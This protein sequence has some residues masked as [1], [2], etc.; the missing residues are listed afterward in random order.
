MTRIRT[1][2]AAGVIVGA[3][4]LGGAGLAAADMHEDDPTQA[5]V[6]E[7]VE[8]DEEGDP[9]GTEDDLDTGEA[10]E[11]EEVEEVEDTEETEVEDDEAE[12][13]EVEDVEETDDA[14]TAET[15]KADNHGQYVS[16][17]AKST[18]PGPEHGPT[19]AA[20]AQEHGHGEQDTDDTDDTEDAE[21][22]GDTEDTDAEEQ[23]QGAAPQAAAGRGR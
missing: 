20:A 8:I 13:T 3:T 10:E 2:T 23:Q 12:E 14:E 5:D 19:V 17:V 9:V 7:V 4:V 18:E 21:D 22:V 11:V 1:L 15:A 16:G 6:D